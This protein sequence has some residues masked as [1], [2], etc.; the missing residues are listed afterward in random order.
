MLGRRGRR[1]VAAAATLLATGTGLAAPARAAEPAEQSATSKDP[2]SMTIASLAPA[3]LPASGPITI[4]GTVTNR[5]KSTWTGVRIYPFF[6]RDAVTSSAALTREVAA[7]SDAYVGDRMNDMAATDL[8]G[9]IAPGQTVDYRLTI[10]R[11]DI[12]TASAG[13][14]WLGARAYGASASTPADDVAD[15]RAR[16]FLPVVKR[17]KHGKHAGHTHHRAPV[18]VSLLLPLRT[19]VLR[20][21]NGRVADEAAWTA[22]LTRGH[23]NSV[24]RFGTTDRAVT[25]LVDPAVLDAVLQLAEGNPVRDI[26]ADAIPTGTPTSTPTDTPTGTASDAASA[27]S[28]S[29][30]TASSTSTSSD[31]T[32]PSASATSSTSAG[33]PSMIPSPTV[34]PDT[35]DPDRQ[36]AASAAQSWLH[37]FLAAVADHEVL[38]LPYGDPDLSATAAHDPSLL[39]EARSA[40]TAVMTGLGISAKPVAAPPDGYLSAAGL[41]S[42]G[43]DTLTV[44]SSRAVRG[45]TD[46][47]VSLAGQQVVLSSAAA[48]AGGPAPGKPFAGVALRQRILAQAALTRHRPLVVELPSTWQAPRATAFFD[49][50]DQPWLR[51]EPLT[52][53]ADDS[54]SAD[55]TAT[56]VPASRLLYPRSAA[57]DQVEPGVFRLVNQMTRLGNALDDILPDHDGV[58]EEVL[59]DA[60]TSTSYSARG[61]HGNAALAS[62]R[63]LSDTLGEIQLDPPPAVTLSGSTGRFAVS[64]TNHLDQ[65]VLVQVK[66]IGDQGI[67]VHT[68]AP[69]T[70]GAGGTT[71]VLITASDTSNGV[72]RVLLH[73]TS[74]TGVTLGSTVVLQIRSAQVSKVIW[75]FLG[76]GLGILAIA[77]GVRLTRRVRR[78]R[79]EV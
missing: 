51:L 35:D 1:L 39:A 63:S 66:P 55:G 19:R 27:S 69:V 17:P 73:L 53:L 6:D 13:V 14:H 67:D 50:L 79:A 20:T 59:R 16:T 54:G 12:S 61:G 22:N 36:A 2:L 43:T 41:A 48:D 49:A 46:A 23:L 30:A 31:P 24:V 68:P 56:R 64:V 62:Q 42:V 77:I 4:T 76:V 18:P 72:H 38:A 57:A 5:D 32:E 15:G 7:P 40:S 3:A 47:V 25:W 60:L 9:D 71:S 33:L 58:A 26:A 70:I 78:A 44:L 29:S 37:R 75:G 28:S 52:A 34:S 11:S 65:R 21:A 8:V 10:P 45:H 74:S